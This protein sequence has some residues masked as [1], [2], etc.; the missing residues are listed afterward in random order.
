MNRPYLCGGSFLRQLHRAFELR[1][2][3]LDTEILRIEFLDP[4][5]VVGSERL[6]IWSPGKFNEL[7]LV[8]NVRQRRSDA[9]VGEQP[10]QR[11]LPERAFRIFKE[12]QLLNLFN[13]IQ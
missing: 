11:R 13:S 7:F 5:H 3:F 9:I 10:L 8:V 1:R 6:A 12:P 4:R 2:R